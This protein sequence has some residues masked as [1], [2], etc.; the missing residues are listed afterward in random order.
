MTPF[1]MRCKTCGDYIAKAKK[2]NARKE[3]VEDESYLGLKIFRFYFKC[4]TCMAEITF[5]TDPKNC[6]YELEHGAIRNFDAFRK[7][8]E[9]AERQAK[10]EEEEEEMNIMKKLEKR[11]KAS[12]KE[13][14]ELEELEDIRDM[15]E[16]RVL[17]DY[18]ELL[19]DQ[20]KKAKKSEEDQKKKEEE[21]DQAFVD[22]FLK[23]KSSCEID[24]E[25]EEV[26]ESIDTNASSTSHVI[27]FGTV[28]TNK[29][30]KSSKQSLG[31]VIKEKSKPASTSSSSQVV[32]K[33]QMQG[34]KLLC[35]YSDSEESE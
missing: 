1:N 22:E 18:E 35:N 5:K 16:K 25:I 24:E 4:P 11:T 31:V 34:P 29:E 14:E 8:Q 32:E 12:R 6:D 19:D 30:P 26:E 3:T 2:F 28:K 15:K 7:A 23:Y 21:E 27:D 10:E 17:V 20:R 13:M 9:M 33:N